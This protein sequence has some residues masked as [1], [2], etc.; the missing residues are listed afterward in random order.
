MGCI[1]SVGDAVVGLD[2]GALDGEN[3]GIVVGD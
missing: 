3:V 2:V 1:N